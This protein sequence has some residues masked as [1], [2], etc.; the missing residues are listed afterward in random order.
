MSMFR[1]RGC[2]GTLRKSSGLDRGWLSHGCRQPSQ[3][4]AL[5][6][7]HDPC[8]G[9]IRGGLEV[10]ATGAGRLGGGDWR[11]MLGGPRCS[12]IRGG[13]IEQARFKGASS[14]GWSKQTRRIEKGRWSGG[15][16]PGKNGA[17]EVLND[18]PVRPI[19][20]GPA[21]CR[22]GPSSGTNP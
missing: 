21:P 20:R 13:S 1:R 2:W 10:L 18:V 17:T 14:T 4:V 5:L 7:C 9:L 19:S 15:R 8:A 3:E 22:A 12:G 11:D 6:R 16:H